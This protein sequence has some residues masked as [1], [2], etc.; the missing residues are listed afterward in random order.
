MGK[1]VYIAMS[2]DILHPGHL[3]II[4]QGQALGTVIL[5]LLTDEAIASYKRLPYLAYEQRFEIMRHL[6]GIDQI[7]P[8]TTLDYR[9]NLRQLKPDYVIH[10]DDWRHGIQ[11]ATRQQVIDT[12]TEWGGRLIEPKYT[13]GISSTLLQNQLKTAG[14]LPG[15][16]TGLLG[17][18]LQAKPM[19]RALEAHNGL[20][21]LVV[22]RAT[23]TG[24][25][26][27]PEQ[28]DAVWV[29]SLTDSAAKG[30]PDTELVD[31]SS[32]LAT[33][34]EILEVTTKPVIFDGDTGGHP[35]HFVHTVRTLERLG[36][37][38]VV[39]E[40]KTGL[41]HNSLHADAS[42]HIQEDPGLF[43]A[44]IRAG[45]EA[46][47]HTDFMIIARI[48]S[49]ITGAGQA[50]A[51][52]HAQ[53]YLEA[54]A[55]AI[56]VHSKSVTGADIKTFATA[57]NRLGN[58]RP[59]MVVPTT[60]HDRYEHELAGWGANIIVYANH[61]L[62]AAYPAMER[63]ATTILEHQRA[64]EAE[65]LCLPVQDLLNLPPAA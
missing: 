47:L 31:L 33:I 30:K 32:R 21:A 50:D 56:M 49:L 26:G 1:T 17:R 15:H 62:R 44:K 16:R 51:L 41:K 13:A 14:I 48:E 9:P 11:Q 39:I 28:F 64:A 5:G 55:A 52:A 25:T 60:Y 38:A 42:G 7:V 4:K 24:T 3:N 2:A 19:V 63:A 10:G 27:R 23:A 54:G 34:N 20:S 59:L 8:Q 40:D 65:A 22:E 43:A 53:V 36:V 35:K 29:S 45:L 58:R 18:L 57:Y 46:R 6:K 37:S 12:L 61:L